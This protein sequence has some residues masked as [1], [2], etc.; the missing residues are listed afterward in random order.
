MANKKI[1]SLNSLGGTPDVADIIP[2]T[3]VSDTTGSVNGTTKKVTVTNL[4]GAAPVQS[5]AG[6]TG[7]VTIANTDVSGLGS[8]A[9][10]NAGTA[11]TNL[12]QL[13]DV[14]GTV[15]LPAVDGS[16]L[17]GLAGGATVNSGTAA[18]LPSSPSVGDIY[19]ETDSGKLRWWSGSV[20]NTFNFDSQL[21]PAYAAN[22]LGYS[23]GLFSST[24][25]NISVQPKMHFDA[26][27][28]DGSDQANNPS[29]GSAVSTWGDRS[30]Q[31]TNYDASQSN[32]SEQPTFNVSGADKY[33][34]F[35]GG[36][37]LDLANSISRSSTQPWTII[38]VGNASS[39]GSTYHA[40][41]NVDNTYGS[42]QLG[43]FSNG[44][45]YVR[46]TT[47][48]TGKDYSALNML[49]ATRNGSDIVEVFRDGN[50]SE[51]TTGT[52]AQTFVFNN[53]GRSGGTR[54]TGNIY[55]TIF[56]DQL[57]STTD[58]NTINSYLAN[59]YS[60]LPS[61]ATWT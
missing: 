25:Y 46:G 19:L 43:V 44:F 10:L 20:W 13:A 60:G 40:A 29:S 11:A 37:D 5:V 54:T 26:A 3:D 14:G 38:Q 6:K 39:S 49:T 34:S 53:I 59:K 42:V 9:T 1:S 16:Q 27:I 58:L 28:L 36:D 48:A 4:M 30:G 41:P 21:D 55:E 50:S 24:N 15:K 18:N 47:L 8:A 22:Q 2:I 57:L 32:A 7:A 33:V 31:A 51:G 12:V 23:G 61:L 52:L 35:D 45:I 17:T 56:F